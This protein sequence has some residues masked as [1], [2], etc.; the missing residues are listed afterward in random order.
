MLLYGIDTGIAA[1]DLD[2]ARA[3]AREALRLARQ[4]ERAIEMAI[5]LQHLAMLS[6]PRGEVNEAARLIGY[7]NVQFKELGYEREATEKWGYAK[8][9]AA[10]HEQLSDAQ[11]ERFATERSGAVGRSD[12]RGSAES[13]VPP[14]LGR[15]PR[16]Y[17]ILTV[18]RA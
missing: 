1:G 6:A 18:L 5:A 12:R 14:R 15:S 7:S 16:T 10:L 13:L 3:A 17:P 11:I 9:I 2:G 8:V 4:V